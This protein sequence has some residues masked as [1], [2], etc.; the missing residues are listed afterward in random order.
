MSTRFAGAEDVLRDKRTIIDT[1]NG[2]TVVAYVNPSYFQEVLT[3]LNE[4]ADAE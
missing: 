1:T 4:Y 3:A 2:R